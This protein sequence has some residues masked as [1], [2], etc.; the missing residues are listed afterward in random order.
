MLLDCLSL[1]QPHQLIKKNHMPATVSQHASIPSTYRVKQTKST[2]SSQNKQSDG[3]SMYSEYTVDSL[4]KPVE[5]E[6]KSKS[7]WRK[8][9]KNSLKDVGLPPTYAYDKAHGIT[10]ID[11]TSMTYPSMG[12]SRL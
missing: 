7:S 4:D 3:A 10:E 12:P 2:M 11:Y 5:Y 9:V 8:K 1:Q 6:A